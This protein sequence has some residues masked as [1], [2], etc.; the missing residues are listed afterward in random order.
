MKRLIVIGLLFLNANLNAE[1]FIVLDNL[2]EAG[3]SSLYRTEIS[4]KEVINTSKVKEAGEIE[5]ISAVAKIKSKLNKEAGA[6]EQKPW[7]LNKSDAP[8]ISVLGG[9]MLKGL[10]LCLG[11]VFIVLSILKRFK[12]SK[13]NLPRACKVIETLKLTEKSK[14][15]LIEIEGKKVAVSVGNERVSTIHEFGDENDKLKIQNKTKQN[16]INEQGLEL[17]CQ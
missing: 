1:D 12:F 13:T 11:M 10:A 5:K 3:K 7:K 8:S 16:I 9:N 14:L 4:S 2:T 6:S 17:L 15:L